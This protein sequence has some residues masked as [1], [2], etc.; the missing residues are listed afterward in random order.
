MLTISRE[1]RNKI[2]CHA[3]NVY[4]L[5][6]FGYLLG[7]R[8][9]E[10]IYAALPCSKTH[11]WDRFDDR[12]NGIVENLALARRIGDQFSL[13][14]VGLYA[15]ADDDTLARDD[16]YPIPD[17]VQKSSMQVFAL[18]SM[19]CC[20]KCSS[21]LLKRNTSWLS[22]LSEAGYRLSTGR[23][24]TISVNQKRILTAW[25]LQFGDVDYSNQ[26]ALPIPRRVQAAD[27]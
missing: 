15:S 1:A 27:S 24:C 18:Y 4:P 25:R 6:A 17:C 20:P 5:E 2:R 26:S 16:D 3:W 21:L 22:T 7:N 14:W 13:E 23:R 12:W 10:T 8:E 9:R 19:I 11:V